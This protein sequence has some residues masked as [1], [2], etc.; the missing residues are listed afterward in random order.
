MEY[1]EHKGYTHYWVTLLTAIWLSYNTSIQYTKGKTPSL[2]ETGWNPLLPVDHLKK[3][4]LTIHPTAKDF[5]D[6]WR[7]AC[8]TAAHCIA[9]AKE[10]NKQRYDKIHKEPDFKE[11]DQVLMSTLNFTDLKV[12]MKI[13]DWFLGLFT[14]IRLTGKNEVEVQLT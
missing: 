5:H 3:D 7:K 6:M 13:T 2:L 8:E 9:E 10:Y 11:G 4:L 12:P 14:I 1:K